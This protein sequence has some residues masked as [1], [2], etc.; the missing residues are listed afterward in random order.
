MP[1]AH[2]T[3]A[4]LKT[5][6]ARRLG[7]PSK[8]FWP[9]AEL[10][11]CLREA[12]HYWNAAAEY[13]RDRGSFTAAAG[14]AWYDLGSVTFNNGGGEALRPRSLTDRDLLNELQCALIEPQN[15]TGWNG[16]SQ[17]TLAGV[18][19]AMQR[20]RDQFL[21]E[22]GL[23]LTRF[24]QNG[25]G[26]GSFR[27]ECSSTGLIDPRRLAWF[28]GTTYEQ[29]W[30]SDMWERQALTPAWQTTPGTPEVWSILNTLSLQVELTPPPI[31][32]GQLEW[33]A[34]VAGP[35][36]DVTAGVALGVPDDWIWPIKYGALADL[37]E[38]DGQSRDFVRADYCRKR[39]QEGVEL[40]RRAASVLAAEVNGSL[41]PVTSLAELD[42]MRPGWQNTSAL[43]DL[44]AM[45]GQDLLA[46]A[47]VPDDTCSVILDVVRSAPV[48]TQ[49][50]TQVQLGQEHLDAV[51]GYAQHVAAFRMGGAE[52]MATVPEWEACVRAAL[53]Y[54]ARLRAHGRFYN[55]LFGRGSLEARRRPMRVETEG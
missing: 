25:V 50:A 1:Y 2:T 35:L 49:D 52:F 24:L 19:A 29:M 20:R 41:V 11:L 4:Q 14:T 43:P 54:N 46:L 48:P 15:A 5:E 44:V 18:Q 6:L 8:V 38:Q 33:V 12:L 36:L 16:T 51:L 30:R 21:A 53:G 39:W 31:S 10:D 27:V 7:D 40:A 37:L 13:W 28:D 45:A 32:N 42:L 23:T 3:W 34:I 17:F 26:A 55:E 22:T 9:D 47:A